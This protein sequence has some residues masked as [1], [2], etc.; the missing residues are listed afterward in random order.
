MTPDRT[1]DHPDEDADNGLLEEPV[2]VHTV[3]IGV[4]TEQVAVVLPVESE[5][6]LDLEDDGVEIPSFESQGAFESQA[7]SV[8]TPSAPAVEPPA[9]AEE[10]Q[11]PAAEVPAAEVPS[12][13]F[14]PRPSGFGIAAVTR[15]GAESGT[16][17]PAAPAPVS[18]EPVAERVSEPLPVVVPVP[19]SAKR[20]DDAATREGSD[21]LTAERLIDPSKRVRTEPEGA[22]QHVLYT[23]SGRRLTLGESRRARERRELDA[24]IGASLAGGAKFVPILSRKGGVGKTTVTTLLGMALADARDDRIIAVDANPDRGTLAERIV[25]PSGRSVRDLAH[26]TVQIGGFNELSTIVARDDTRLDVLASD[27]DPRV[28]EA[29]SDTDYR[30]VAALAAHYYSIVLTDTGT[31]IVHSVM[32][33][34]LALADVLVIVSGLSVD[35]AR[36]ASETLTWLETNG[37]GDKARSAIVVL[38]TSRPGAPLVRVDELEAHFGSRAATVVRMPYDGAIAAGSTITFSELQ[39]VTRDAARTLAAAVVEGLRASA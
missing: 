39:P 33:A 13:A 28:S 25:R 10:P 37:Y 26:S 36:L 23:L 34:T 16:A 30:D 9:P 27:A 21:V 31:G 11:A 2:A 20:V 3:G 4:A 17:T 19:L 35:E 38:N 1:E 18:P 12:L 32:D 6:D 7:S 24:R 29:F 5:D 8:R 14:A 15:P 22:W